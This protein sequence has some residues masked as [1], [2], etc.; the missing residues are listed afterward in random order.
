VKVTWKAIDSQYLRDQIG[1]M[2]TSAKKGVHTVLT[3]VSVM[4]FVA[5]LS[6]TLDASFLLQEKLFKVYRIAWNSNGH[7]PFRFMQSSS[8]EHHLS[9]QGPRNCE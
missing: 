8:T 1:A 7:A 6:G 3:L 9:N 2:G 4:Y 5:V